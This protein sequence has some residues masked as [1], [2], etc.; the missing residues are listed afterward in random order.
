MVKG[1]EGNNKE[2]STVPQFDLKTGIWRVFLNDG[3]VVVM[4]TLGPS[5]DRSFQRLSKH[6]VPVWG[7][8][9][10]WRLNCTIR[11]DQA[12][13]GPDFS[14]FGT[15]DLG[16]G[17]QLLL[18]QVEY[19]AALKREL[20]EAMQSFGEADVTTVFGRVSQ[21][22]GRKVLEL[23]ATDGKTYAYS[24]KTTKPG[25]AFGPETSAFLEREI[26]PALKVPLDSLW[27]HLVFYPDPATCKLDWHSDSENGLNPHCIASITFLE[28]TERGVRP[29]D[30]RLKSAVK[31]AKVVKEAKKQ[32]R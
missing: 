5:L 15:N 18:K 31:E 24:G 23:A 30:I 22:N 13:D 3:S 29:F 17:L 26:V 25:R 6:R 11:T 9:S 16:E 10:G 1:S 4:F 28:D 21:N 32:K 27:C 20:F 8:A 2:L 19:P 12:V 14:T 7:K